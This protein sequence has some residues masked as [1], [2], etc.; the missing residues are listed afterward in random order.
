MCSDNFTGGI[1]ADEMG[2][3][4]TVEIIG[5]IMSHRRGE[6]PIIDD[7]SKM[8]VDC[9]EIIVDEMISTVVASIDGYAALQDLVCFEHC[10]INVLCLCNNANVWIICSTTLFLLTSVLDRLNFNK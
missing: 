1:L 4:K 8:A 5:L 2:L 9:I 6:L 3:G 7:N 10:H